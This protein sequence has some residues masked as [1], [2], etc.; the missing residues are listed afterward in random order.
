MQEMEHER[1]FEGLKFAVHRF[2]KGFDGKVAAITQKQ[3]R[4]NAVNRFGDL[5]TATLQNNQHVQIGF[6]AQRAA[7]SG[8]EQNDSFQDLFIPPAYGAYKF[9][10]FLSIRLGQC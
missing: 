1:G 6:L 8:S 3:I 9:L 4:G 7:G 10:E 5:Q 2:G